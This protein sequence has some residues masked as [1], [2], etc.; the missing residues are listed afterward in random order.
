[1]HTGT[2]PCALS[3]A[4]I[5]KISRRITKA[6]IEKYGVVLHTIGVYSINTKDEKIIEAKKEIAKIVFSHEGVLQMHG[7]YLDEEEKCINF[8]IIIDFKIKEREKVY[9]EIY[10]EV[11][12]KFK[13]YKIDINLDIDVSD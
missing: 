4:D 13:D 9:K 1:M 8:D 7:F 10:E 5:D 11:Q 12:E 2:S 3:V 6:I